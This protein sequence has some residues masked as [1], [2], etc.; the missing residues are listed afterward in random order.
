MGPGQTQVPHPD[1]ALGQVGPVQE[2]DARGA[3]VVRRRGVRRAGRAAAGP[4]P[5]DPGR[6]LLD[7]VKGRHAHHHQGGGGRGELPAVKFLQIRDPDI[8]QAADISRHRMAVGRIPEKQAQV[9]DIGHLPGIVLL[10]RQFGPAALGQEGELVLG[11]SRGSGPLRPGW[12]SAPGN[13]PPA[14]PG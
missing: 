11:E 3:Q 12:P 10:V 7:P 14:L 1:F 9:A 6:L 13:P 2:I 5:P 4:V 8:I